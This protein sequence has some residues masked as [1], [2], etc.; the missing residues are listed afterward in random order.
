MYRSLR[1]R[2][3]LVVAATVSLTVLSIFLLAKNEM[4][5]A[6]TSAGERHARDLLHA[7][8]LSV[9]TEYDSLLFHR[10]TTLE[11]R[12]AELENIIDI[13]LSSL[14]EN[15]HKQLNKELSPEQARRMASETIRRLRYDH[16]VGYFW[17]N[18]MQRPVP[19]MIMHPTLPELNG[20]VLDNPMFN[21]AQ[22]INE[23]LFSAAVNVCDQWGEG[24]VDYLWPKPT[25][26]GLTEQQPKI[27]YVRLF[28]PWNWVLGTGVYIDDIESETQK[29]LS[30][31]ILE[32]KKTFANV[33]VAN[34]GYM[35]L[36]NGKRE[37]LIHPHLEKKEFASLVNP[38]TQ[39]PL[40]DD[41]MAASRTPDQSIDYIWDKPGFKGEYRFKKRAFITYFEPLDWYIGS[42]MY[43]DELTRPSIELQN[44]I[45]LLSLLPFAVAMLIA[46]FLARSMTKPLW[47]LTRAARTI[48]SQGLAAAD[49][50]IGGTREIQALGRVLEEMV[51]SL[52]RTEAQLCSANWELETFVNTVSHDLRAPLA[53]II[54]YAQLLKEQHRDK[55]DEEAIGYID[56]IEAQAEK[57]LEHMEDLLTLS[58]SGYLERPD[59]PIS[60]QDVIQQVLYNLKECFSE[61]EF[62]CFDIHPLPLVSL[63]ESQ[64][65]EV[66][67]NLISNSIRY[68][69]S[70]DEPIEIGAES[71]GDKVRFYV[72]DHGQ[73]IPEEEREGIFRLFE[74]GS[75]SC[76]TRGTGIGLA[77]VQKVAQTY[78]GGAWVEETPGGGCTFW[79]EFEE[80]SHDA[81]ATMNPTG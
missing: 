76:N 41:L 1:S 7:I 18:D 67:A 53:P 4:T 70:E 62:A 39:A 3:L 37:M 65:Y 44:R 59:S 60:S 2:L 43:L 33:R 71:R 20:K 52:R 34:T 56:E 24:F 61:E 25:A 81:S 78:G 66:F 74:R 13:A 75:T 55:L 23:N 36:F 73:G 17:I 35:F 72:R 54:G 10:A 9:S 47:R 15:H 80:P 14:E 26:E 68:S 77:I 51:E 28:K 29:R 38:A 48:E 46:L 69:K 64:F 50:P 79:V 45:M 58:K 6:I 19:R 22:G 40:V 8:S 63:P 49:I 42:S 21:T 27:S 12:K 30:A 5:E 11:R 57:M 32:L 31:I 16:G